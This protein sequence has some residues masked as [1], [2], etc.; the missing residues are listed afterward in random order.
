MKRK[1]T[2]LLALAAVAAI[3][4]SACGSTGDSQSE[5]LESSDYVSSSSV[6]SLLGSEPV[7]ITF[8]HS[9]SDEAG[10]LM[11]KFIEDFNN[12]NEY[13]ITVKAVYQGSYSDATTLLQSVLSAENYSELPDVMQT[14][15]TGKIPYYE[16]GRAFTA[17]DAAAEYEESGYFDNYI[18]PALLN[19]EYA[20]VQL[21]VPF[22]T[23]TTI[24]Y[25]NE[26][27]LKAAGYT[28]CPDSIDGAIE[29]YSAMQEAGIDAKVLQTVP[30][31]PSLANWLGQMGSYL[32]SEENGTRGMAESLDCIDNG[33]LASFLTKWKEFYDS[34]ALINESTSLDAFVAGDVAL[35]EASSSGVAS[36]VDQVGTTFTVGTSQMLK[37]SDDASSGASVSGSC[38]VMFDSEDELKKEASWEFVKYLTSDEV[39]IEF[40]EGTGYIPA[41]VSAAESSE[42]QTYLEE[43]PQFKAG[44]E[45]LIAT[46][47]TMKS[48]TVGPSYDFYFTIM[49]SV[50]DMLE[51]D[52][53][54][55]ETVNTMNESLTGL[56]EEYAKNNS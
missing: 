1:F 54:V 15:A 20:G 38:L 12:N 32:V 29:L 34:G 26:D 9:A 52:Y 56:L 2:A 48:V 8:W 21:G 31:T 55:E 22:A 7:E 53:T 18:S 30:S 13:S 11:D 49:T 24:T 51:N 45:Q 4:L 42:Y 3:M 23:S 41:T 25:Y 35:M 19:W 14:D 6:S 43:N 16:S 47:D 28:E 27:I 44:Y 5:P 17:Q 46:P 33:A 36:V 40:A 10:V 50:S 37:I 39:Q